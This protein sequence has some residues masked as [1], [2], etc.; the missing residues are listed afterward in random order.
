MPSKR[1]KKEF[2]QD[3]RNLLQKGTSRL[4]SFLEN[5]KFILGLDVTKLVAKEIE[6]RKGTEERVAKRHRLQILQRNNQKA[7]FDRLL[8]TEAR[9]LEERGI[10]I[11]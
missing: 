8:I 3:L 1:F 7:V 9:K 11:W 10:G 2:R 5:E 6:L 4:E